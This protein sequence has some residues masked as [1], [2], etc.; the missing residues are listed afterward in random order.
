MEK[1]LILGIILL[2][3]SCQK[4]SLRRTGS[5]GGVDADMSSGGIPATGGVTSTAGLSSTGGVRASG[6]ASAAP[7]ARADNRADGAIDSASAVETGANG[8]DSPMPLRCGDRVNHST[9]VQGRPNSWTA[10][11]C[12]AQWMSGRESLYA[13]HSPVACKV[14]VRFSSSEPDLRLIRL[15]SCESMSCTSVPTNA[16]LFAVSA[17]Q[18]KLF[19]VDGYD[20]AA[21][22]Y[23]LEVDCECDRDAGTVDTR[24]ADAVK[25]VARP[26]TC[27]P[28]TAQSVLSSLGLTTLGEPMIVNAGLPANLTA[29]ANWGLKA[30]VCKE[31]GYDLGRLAGRTVCLIGQD[32][33]QRCQGIPAK[34]WVVLDGDAMA[35][36]YKTVQDGFPVAPGVYSATD[37]ACALPVIGPGAS[38][39]CE[40]RNCT[41]ENGGLCCPASLMMSRT[42]VCSPNCP[43]AGMPCDG[44]DDCSN[45]SVCCSM[46]SA[47]GFRGTSCVNPSLCASPSRLICRETSDCPAAQTCVRPDPMPKE[48]ETT[49]QGP[50]SI[51]WRVDYKVCAP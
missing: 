33:A 20:G 15:E 16:P 5:D 47:A 27:E 38:V 46:E 18:T 42:G 28:R 41:S 40:G 17:G 49:S 37:P 6:G 10:Y 34:A 21:G 22:S 44:P 24:A 36:V 12:T 35:C 23:T 25:D 1:R 3:G 43:K 8:C 2:V 26:L 13:L 32:I 4:S 31:A 7:D 19:V 39:D 51:D 30:T 14:A 48:I 11:A 9:L 45:G 29:D 50:T